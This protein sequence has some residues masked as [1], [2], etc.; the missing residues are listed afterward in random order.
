MRKVS[1][2]L[3]IFILLVTVSC[4]IMPDRSGQKVSILSVGLDY[5]DNIYR[6]LEGTV[7]DAKEVGMALKSL[8]DDRGIEY[9]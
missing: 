1:I 4:S 3:L 2:V 6:D 7:N 5:K 8:Y 9:Y